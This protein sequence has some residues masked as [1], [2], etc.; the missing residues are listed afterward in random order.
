[1]SSHPQATRAFN[2]LPLDRSAIVAACTG[3][4]SGRDGGGGGA[5]GGGVAVVGEGGWGGEGS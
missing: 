4:K 5:G 1:M 3:P 2:L